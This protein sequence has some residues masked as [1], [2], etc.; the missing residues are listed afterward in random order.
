MLGNPAPLY[1]SLLRHLGSYRAGVK[2]LST[3]LAVLTEANVTCYLPDLGFVRVWLDRVEVFLGANLRTT[4]EGKQ[5]VQ[6]TWIALTE[7]DEAL[8]LQRH[9]V[10]LSIWARFLGEETFS[11]YIRRFATSPKGAWTPSVEFVE[12]AADGTRA[13][14]VKLEESGML[15]EGLFV[16]SVISVGG[17]VSSLEELASTAQGAFTAQLKEVQLEF[18]TSDETGAR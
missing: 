10:S 1:G 11:T 6:D 13:G 18:S 4:D 7:V 17:V 3:N 16:H 9:Q 5:I 12:L 8:R 14:S 2:D 15:K